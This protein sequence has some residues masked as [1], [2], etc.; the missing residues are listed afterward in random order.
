VRRTVGFRTVSAVPSSPARTQRFDARLSVQEK[1]LLDRAAEISGRSLT[2][3]V[4]G[5]AKEA[6]LRAIERYDGMVLANPD[7]QAAFVSTLLKP[8]APNRHL[9]QAVQRQRRQL[10]P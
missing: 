6:A 5:T 10:R 7:D 2:E 4:I 1:R 8:P 3:F 9:R